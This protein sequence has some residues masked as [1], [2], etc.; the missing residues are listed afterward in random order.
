MK[1]FNY[2]VGMAFFVGAFLIYFDVLHP[3]LELIGFVAC[4]AY[5]RALMST[6]DGDA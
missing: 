5:A 3:D 6:R 2:L 1:T 4:L